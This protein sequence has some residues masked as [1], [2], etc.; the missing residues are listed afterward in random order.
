M[1]ATF[2][3]GVRSI[4]NSFLFSVFFH[5]LLLLVGASFLET[6]VRRERRKELVWITTLPSKPVPVAP[7]HADDKSR[8]V[9]QSDA[10][11]IS[12]IPAPDA[13]LGEKTRVVDRQTVSKETQMHV[14]ARAARPPQSAQPARQANDEVKAPPKLALGNLGI[15]VLSKQKE[16]ERA[17]AASQPDWVQPGQDARDQM[18]GMREGEQTALNTR[19][20]SFF[21]YHQRIRERLEREWKGLLRQALTKFV[22]QGRHLASEKE[23]VTRVLVVLGETGDVKRVQV[24]SPSGTEELDDVAVDAFRKA[25]PFPNPPKGLIRNGEVEVAWELKLHS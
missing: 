20:Y 23:H 5:A 21:G 10:G 8:K 13:F 17:V 11:K 14:G 24:L 6:A 4:K 16:I 19:E 15:P 2:P 9:V 1:N 25:G 12:N 7:T 22:R 3:L 18:N